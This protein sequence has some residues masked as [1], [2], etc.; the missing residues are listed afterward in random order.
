MQDSFNFCSVLIDKYIVNELLTSVQQLFQLLSKVGDLVGGAIEGLLSVALLSLR[1]LVSVPV[2]VLLPDPQLEVVCLWDAGDSAAAFLL[3]G[4]E[5]SICELSLFE[6][7]FH[8]DGDRL[9]YRVRLKSLLWI[10]QEEGAVFTAEQV[11]G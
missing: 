6:V 7:D 2:E 10:I 4:Q 11:L 5:V 9:P 8:P 3:R 1:G